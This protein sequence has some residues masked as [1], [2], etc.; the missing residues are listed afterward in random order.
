MK[1]IRNKKNYLAEC[2]RKL[3]QLVNGKNIIN[4]TLVTVVLLSPVIWQQAC[5]SGLLCDCLFIKFLRQRPSVLYVL[6]RSVACR[7]FD[8]QQLDLELSLNFEERMTEFS[9]ISICLKLF[10]LPHLVCVMCGCTARYMACT[11]QCV[12]A[13]RN[14]NNV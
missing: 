7:V 9:C 10:F 2:F 12:I 3:S 5:S 14:G 11:P 13:D 1:K 8:W 4:D 6:Y